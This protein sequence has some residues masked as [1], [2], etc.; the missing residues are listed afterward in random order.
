[1]T[2]DLARRDG[3]EV[4]ESVE[5]PSSSFTSANSTS[6]T[7]ESSQ[8]LHPGFL[9]SD[10]LILRD[11]GFSQRR[12]L[13]V[14]TRSDRDAGL[15]NLLEQLLVG[16]DDGADLEVLADAPNAPTHRTSNAS[17]RPH[18]TNQPLLPGAP[19][20]QEAL[21]ESCPICLEGYSLA[22]DRHKHADCEHVFHVHCFAEHLRSRIEAG[23]SSD[24]RCP[25]CPREVAAHEVQTL[26]DGSIWERYQ[27]LR[28]DSEVIQDGTRRFCAMPGCDGVVRRPTSE[29]CVSVSFFIVTMIAVACV[30]SSIGMVAAYLWRLPLLLCCSCCFS[31]TLIGFALAHFPTSGARSLQSAAALSFGFP[32]PAKCETCQNLTCF[33][34]GSPWHPGFVCADARDVLVD[35]WAESCDAARCPRCQTMIER[36][37]GCNHMTCRRG[38]GGCGYEFC[39]LCGSEYTPG[40]FGRGRCVQY[41]GT[42]KTFD[43]FRGSY[44]TAVRAPLSLALG[45]LVVEALLYIP[46]GTVWEMLWISA[47]CLAGFSLLGATKPSRPLTWPMIAAAPLLALIFAGGWYTV[48]FYCGNVPAAVLA[49]TISE[50]CSWRAYPPATTGR[51]RWRWYIRQRACMSFTLLLACSSSVG[52][53]WSL[54]LL[55]H[56]DICKDG[57]RNG[58][59]WAMTL[60]LVGGLCV[61]VFI[62]CALT[63]SGYMTK[64]GLRDFLARDA[65]SSLHMSMAGLSRQILIV[66]LFASFPSALQSFYGIGAA[67]L[68]CLSL[69]FALLMAV[70]CASD[71]AQPKRSQWPMFLQVC[72]A[73]WACR[74]ALELATHMSSFTWAQPLI[75]FYTLA[76]VFWVAGGMA[77]L[78]CVPDSMHEDIR[79]ATRRRQRLMSLFTRRKKQLLLWLI[80]VV[81]ALLG[82]ALLSLRLCVTGLS[83]QRVFAI[84]TA[85]VALAGLLFLQIYSR[86]NLQHYRAWHCLGRANENAS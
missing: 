83:V 30:T 1:M 59:G 34:C 25:L 44:L 62:L 68:L 61:G 77:G 48:Y 15:N 84:S 13:N 71:V 82:L 21:Q 2:E 74:L 18:V 75:R 10:I 69:G 63:F 5:D 8:A 45:V 28:R 47:M 36:L 78:F 79:M 40:H 32:L 42:N 37:A 57:F 80:Q 65:S 12:I 11:M 51:S 4:S 24:L 41:G 58:C 72:L 3:R 35:V 33:S 22:A 9:S 38:F 73:T 50:F 29:R 64:P 60:R 14:L 85:S 66:A 31:A 26:V 49:I 52:L 86:I 56:S 70:T 16:V 23:A 67:A 76:C 6:R 39:W 54:S 46:V 20:R 7:P 53:V 81:G 17:E 43:I 55:D 19:S 27:Q